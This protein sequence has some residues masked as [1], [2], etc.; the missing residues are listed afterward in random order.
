MAG[1][2]DVQRLAQLTGLDAESVRTQLVPF[3]TTFTTADALRGHLVDLLGGSNQARAFINDYVQ[4]RF[5]N[6]RQPPSAPK[7]Q[8]KPKLTAKQRLLQP[9]QARRI[10]DE[11]MSNSAFG[12]VGTVYH[13][14]RDAVLEGYRTPASAHTSSA[15]PAG[16]EEPL[17]STSKDPTRVAQ[18][19]SAGTSTP[20][21]A[22]AHAN[23]R[24]QHE[25]SS[26]VSAE[27][28]LEQIVPTA[29]MVEL[30]SLLSDLTAPEDSQATAPAELVVCFC[31]GR[32][33]PLHPY[34]PLCPACALPLCTSLLPSP[35]HSLS[36]CP[37]CAQ[38]PILPQSSP[39]RSQLIS[40]LRTQRAALEVEERQRIE[41]VR[42][43]R[44]LRREDAR[45]KATA[46]ANAFPALAGQSGGAA[47]SS[48]T[49]N[50]TYGLAGYGARSNAVALAMGKHPLTEVER[51][52]QQQHTHRVL[53]IPAK[54]SVPIKKSS[55]KKKAKVKAE[56]SDV[57]LEKAKPPT[58]SSVPATP[59]A[60]G[61]DEDESGSDED[62]LVSVTILVADEDDDG[63]LA[64]QPTSASLVS[65]AQSAAIERQR[66][67]ASTQG[68]QRPFANPR[69]DPQLRP[70]YTPRKEREQ[71]KAAWLAELEADAD[72]PDEDAVIASGG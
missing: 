31:H 61:G 15:A 16:R 46:A 59:A 52:A 25:P 10:V 6:A 48:M 38:S 5:P 42:R 36:R 13:K 67:L 30:D 11:E 34:Q 65:E 41:L 23:A 66:Q 4:A 45:D 9:A 35:L 57:Q 19:P 70:T 44:Q 2:N 33:H 12:P 37:S 27:P 69:L 39:A 60:D 14:D 62:A 64:H 55:K 28:E 20:P 40:S 29:A 17:T 22:Q 32:V 47:L 50:R 54:G 3:L 24:L 51:V 68:G 71:R 49:P 58:S 63:W 18:P 21:Q 7:A 43:E 53:R 8:G 56:A 72:G 1:D 26:T